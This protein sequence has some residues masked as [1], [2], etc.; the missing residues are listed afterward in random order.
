MAALIHVV[1]NVPEDKFTDGDKAQGIV[2]TIASK[3]GIEEKVTHCQYF[4]NSL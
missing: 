2:S 4:R 1:T 3:F